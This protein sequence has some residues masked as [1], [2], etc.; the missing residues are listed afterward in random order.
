LR[1]CLCVAPQRAAL[2]EDL[3]AVS[4][5]GLW[6]C[7]SVAAVGLIAFFPHDRRLEAFTRALRALGESGL[8][9]YGAAS[10]LAAITIVTGFER[11]ARAGEALRTVL[12]LPAN[13]APLKPEFRVQ[14][15]ER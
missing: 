1:I 7:R 4:P 15:I 12:A 5:P 13:H 3:A 10:S 9:V 6:S 2:A 11:L 8:P 14:P